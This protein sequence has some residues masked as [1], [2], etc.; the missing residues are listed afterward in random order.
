MSDEMVARLA[1]A[2]SEGSTLLDRLTR[3]E[4]LLHLLRALERPEGQHLLMGLSKA[5]SLTVGQIATSPPSSGGITG[6]WKLAREPGV[7]DALRSLSVLGQFW[8][9]SMRQSD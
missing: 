5:L 7:Q 2:I 9:E 3:N 4:G 6:L 1:R 8:V